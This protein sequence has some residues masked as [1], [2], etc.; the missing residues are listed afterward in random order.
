MLNRILTAAAAGLMLI[1]LGT[2]AKAW[3]IADMNKVID[4]TNFLV[5]DSCSGT[6]VA[7][8]KVLTAAHCIL[9]QYKTVEKE[10]IKDDGTIKK[11]KFQIAVPGTVS[12]QVYSGP[13][14]TQIHKYVYKIVKSDR[15]FDLALLELQGAPFNTT[16]IPPVGCKEP[17]RGEQVFAVG[18]SFGVLYST[19]TR[20]IVSSNNRSYRDLQIGGDLGNTTDSGENGLVQHDAVI[21]GGNSGGALYDDVGNLVGVNVRGGRSGFSFAVPLSDV[22]EFLKDNVEANCG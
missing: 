12:Q 4:H 16:V 22:R 6:L 15:T 11:E 19:I 9:H 8:N 20:G 18:N 17:G 21:A 7:P 14:I 13:A 3:D 1:G 2:C 10:V 5:N